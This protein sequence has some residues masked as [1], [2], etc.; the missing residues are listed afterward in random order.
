MAKTCAG[1]ESKTAVASESWSFFLS[2]GFF[3]YI[4]NNSVSS[5]HN[6]SLQWSIYGDFSIVQLSNYDLERLQNAWRPVFHWGKITL[7]NSKRLS[8]EIKCLSMFIVRYG[9]FNM[10]LICTFLPFVVISSVVIK[11]SCLPE[12]KKIYII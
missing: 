7:I 11:N 3:Y 12:R 2:S 5:F 10:A 8:N 1:L 4:S 9:F 6:D